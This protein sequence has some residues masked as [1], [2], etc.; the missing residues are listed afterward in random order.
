MFFKLGVIGFGGPAAHIAL[1]R[2][3]VVDRRKEAPGLGLYSERL[4]RVLREGGRVV[5][6]LNRKGRARLLACAAC[7]ELARCE[8]CEAAVA[9]GDGGTDAVPVLACRACGA[10]RPRVC[11]RCGRSCC[12]VSAFGRSEG[13]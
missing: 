5:C 2:Q 6:V 7:G 1:M 12:P 10:T 3:E 9:E 8:R 13:G 4:V 11:A